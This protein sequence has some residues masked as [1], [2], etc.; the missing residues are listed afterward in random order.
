MIQDSESRQQQLMKTEEMR[1]T[2]QLAAGYRTQLTTL[3]RTLDNKHRL[4]LATVYTDLEQQ[5]LADLQ[6][7][8]VTFSSL[9]ER[10]S[11]QAQQT[12]TLV[13]LIQKASYTPK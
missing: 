7:I 6:R 12:Q 10:A 11:Q 8:R 1:L 5:R 13:D 3:A 4:D 9:D 2:D